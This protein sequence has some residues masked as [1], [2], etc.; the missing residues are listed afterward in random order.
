MKRAHI[1]LTTTFLCAAAAGSAAAQDRDADWL[2]KP[3]AESLMAVWP[4]QGLERGL[5]GSV[6]LNCAVTVQGALRACSVILETPP[7]LG[8][9]A[10][11]LALTPQFLMKPA[12]KGGR[13]VESAVNIP[14]NFPAPAK[15]LGS[16]ITPE[17]ADLMGSEVVYG[18][19]PWVQAPTFAAVMA[20]Y[21]AKARAQQAAGF[22]TL[23]CR[24]GPEGKLGSCDVLREEPKG[25]E[26]GKAAKSLISN[27]EAPTKDSKGV[28]LGRYRTSVSVTFA[29]EALKSAEPMI[30]KPK[31]TALPSFEDVASV[32]PPAAKAAGVYKARVVLHCGVYAR[33]GVGTCKVLTE[34]PTGL[35]YGAAALALAPSF[36]LA[37]WTDEGLPS[38]GG[39][40][41][42]PVRFDLSSFEP[43]K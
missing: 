15:A 18:N 11:A 8:F 33:G 13:P 5:G 41:R 42:I 31:W 24:V 40:V 30:G 35:G 12:T 2:K 1:V 39:S 14:I 4:R 22:V 7:G 43:A 10:A 34:E 9:G 29:P 36:R 25:L 27:F 20:A 23:N 21:P 6:R 38:V 37:L 19:I 17:T 32:L 28:V 16:R 3:T 26:F